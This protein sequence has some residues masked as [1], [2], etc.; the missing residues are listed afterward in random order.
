MMKIGYA[1]VSTTDQNLDSQTAALEQ[2][3]CE[4]LYVDEGVTGN[5]V[6][7]PELD[8][9]MDALREGDMVVFTALDRLARNL[10]HLWTITERIHERGAS[11][12]AINQV[13]DTSTPQGKLMFQMM[14]TVAEFERDLIRERAAEGLKRAKANGKHCGRPFKLDERQVDQMAKLREAGT[15]LADLTRTFGVSQSTV[16]RYLA[17]AGH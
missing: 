12:Q 14:G 16:R 8:R 7:R 2:A 9:L 1:R 17:N 4:R 13:Y 15:S 10:R 6:S 11:L 3:G 5:S